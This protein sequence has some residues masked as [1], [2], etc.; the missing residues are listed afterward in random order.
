MKNS[1]GRMQVCVVGLGRFGTSLARTLAQ[2]S[3]VLAIDTDMERVNRISEFVQ[4]AR[5]LDARDLDALSAVVTSEFQQAAVCITEHL[6]GSILCTLHLKHIGVPT[7]IAK[8]QNEDHA[9]ILRSVGATMIVH[10]ERE[11][12]ERLARRLMHPNLLDFVPLAGGFRVMDMTPP[13]SFVGHSL[14]DLQLRSKHGIF[15]IGA[16]GQQPD[17]FLLLPGPDHVVSADEILV[18]IGKEQD[19]LQLAPQAA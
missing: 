5:C 1:K 8:A 3:D 10:P 16:R 9:E 18:V 6:E 4:M 14:A 12:A 13:E 17:Q 2:E 11:S 15:V 19:L 7:I